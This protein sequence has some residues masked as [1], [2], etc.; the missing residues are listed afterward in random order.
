MPSADVRAVL[1]LESRVDVAVEGFLIRGKPAEGSC[2]PRPTSC[3]RY[4]LRSWACLHVPRHALC[5]PARSATEDGRLSP[6]FRA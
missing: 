6:R 4:S 3:L 2:A 5:M 1:Q